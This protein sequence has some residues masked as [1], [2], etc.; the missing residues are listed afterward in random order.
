MNHSTRHPC[1]SEQPRPSV[2]VIG[3]GIAGLTAAWLLQQRYTVTVFEQHARPGMGVFTADYHSNGISSR[4]DIPTRIFSEG[5]YPSLMALFAAIG[6]RMHATDHSACYADAAGRLYFHYGTVNALGI[7]WT[8]PKGIGR[9]Y[10]GVSLDALRFFTQARRELADPARLASESFADYLGRVRLGA[11]FVQGVLLPTLSVICTCD[12]DEVL[13]YPADL[14]L[15][16]MASGVMKQGV[17]RAEH[18]VDDIVPRLLAGAETLCS[19][20]VTGL[21]RREDG[22]AVHVTDAAP[23]RFDQVVVASQAQQAARLLPAQDRHRRLLEQVPVARSSMLVH[24][25]TSLLPRSR[26]PLSPVSF[27]LPAGSPRPEVSVDLT[28]AFDGFAGQA[29]VFQT[30]NPLR[31]VAAGRR[32]AEASFTRPTVTLT[33]RAAV[34]QLDAMQGDGL[35]FCGAYMADKV[36]LLEAAAG[37]AMDVASRLGAPPPWQG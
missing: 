7:S 4:I 22:W 20:S 15:G 31:D 29:P 28:R 18:G 5:Y 9:R 3:S 26:L 35:W 33:S 23:R 25:D 21:E 34:R 30:W 10:V 37:S 14:V 12:H 6:V 36:P 27:H 32:I 2:A 17:I 13:A 16:C 11:A 24:T 19:A 8:Y 1:G